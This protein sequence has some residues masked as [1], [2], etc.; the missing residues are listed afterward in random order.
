MKT[1]RATRCRHQELRQKVPEPAGLAV[2]MEVHD[3]LKFFWITDVRRGKEINEW[4]KRW[5]ETATSTLMQNSTY[6]DSRKVQQT[7]ETFG[8]EK[9]ASKQFYKNFIMTVQFSFYPGHLQLHRDQSA[10]TVRTRGVFIRLRIYLFHWGKICFCYSLFSQYTIR[11]NIRYNIRAN[12]TLC[13]RSRPKRAEDRE[14]FYFSFYFYKIRASIM[15]HGIWIFAYPDLS[16]TYMYLIY[17]DNR[18]CTVYC[19]VWGVYVKF[20]LTTKI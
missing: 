19:T 10:S 11:V 3:T 5:E 20:G 12:I 15:S 9:R 13:D 14:H 7:E 6:V 16:P 2:L 4:K 8:S 17:S 18:R 1:C